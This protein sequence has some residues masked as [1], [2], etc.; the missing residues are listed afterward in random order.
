MIN[1]FI[2]FNMLTTFG[3]SV[4]DAQVMVCIAKYESSFKSDAIN[5]DL[6]SDGSI[7]YGLFQINGKLW[8]DKCNMSDRELLTPEA[9][10]VC[11]KK[12]HRQLG[13]DGWVAYKKNKQTCDNYRLFKREGE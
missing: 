12:V 8:A 9:N 7:D 13:F 6:N 11:A 1:K 4:P 5:K 10:I 3:F 2:L